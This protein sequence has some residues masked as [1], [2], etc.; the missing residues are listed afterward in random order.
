LMPC[1]WTARRMYKWWHDDYRKEQIWDF[2]DNAGGTQGIDVINNDLIEV[3]D[4]NTLLEN[5]KSSW[6]LPSISEGKLN[7]C[8]QKCG[9]D[10]DTFSEQFK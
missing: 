6:S 8:S 7:V 5:I 4:K 1:C 10:F 9:T 2:I 3:I